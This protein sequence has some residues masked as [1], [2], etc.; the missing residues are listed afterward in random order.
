MS[1]LYLYFR[2]TRA[3]AFSKEAIA[4]AI[5]LSETF[6]TKIFSAGRTFGN[7]EDGGIL[8]FYA[9]RTPKQLKRSLIPLLSKF[10]AWT[11]HDCGDNAA[12]FPQDALMG[13]FLEQVP[14]EGFCQIFVR[15]NAESRPQNDAVDR[16]RGELD[17]HGICKPVFHFRNGKIFAV[18]SH[19]PDKI[20]YRR[21][22]NLVR[23]VPFFTFVDREGTCFSGS[24]PLIEGE[25]WTP[26]RPPESELDQWQTA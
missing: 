15:Y 5:S 4:E 2:T 21:C 16:L 12:E 10:D 26:I 17:R 9:N 24:G 14:P 13:V 19:E 8:K 7:W 6:E 11:C 22:Q 23:Q 20:L 3:L 1:D 25:A 18:W